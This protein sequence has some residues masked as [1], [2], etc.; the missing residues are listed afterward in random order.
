MFPSLGIP[1]ERNQF[2]KFLL[3]KFI[4]LMVARINYILHCY[5]NETRLNSSTMIFAFLIY[6]SVANV[7]KGTFFLVCNLKHEN[8]IIQQSLSHK[9]NK[10][11]QDHETTLF[12]HSETT[13]ATF[14]MKTPSNL[15][16]AKLFIKISF[17]INR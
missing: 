9:V 11:L 5:I 1:W 7:A 14:V 10:Q 8:T 16:K 4:L 17:H 3:G 12:C 2:S 6:S 15:V 13:P